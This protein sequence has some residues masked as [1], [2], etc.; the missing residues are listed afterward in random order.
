MVKICVKQLADAITFDRECIFNHLQYESKVLT[1]FIS[2][3]M[4]EL[5]LECNSRNKAYFCNIKGG[6]DQVPCRQQTHVRFLGRYSHSTDGCKANALDL[7]SYLILFGYF[8]FSL[9]WL[10]IQGRKSILEYT[11]IKVIIILI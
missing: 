8:T 1:S 4:Q 7:T 9:Y 2:N 3:I 10:G 6:Y 5:P 11:I